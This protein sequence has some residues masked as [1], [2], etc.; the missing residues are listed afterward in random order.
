MSE[1]DLP[2]CRASEK[3][4]RLVVACNLVDLSDDF[5]NGR[6]DPVMLDF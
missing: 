6:V 2:R 5:E 3:I 1:N 4:F